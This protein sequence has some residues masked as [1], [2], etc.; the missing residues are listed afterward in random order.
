MRSGRIKILE[1]F[2]HLFSGQ[3]GKRRRF[4]RKKA[5]ENHSK[6]GKEPVVGRAKTLKAPLRRLHRRE[7]EKKGRWGGGR[8]R[9]I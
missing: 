8:E 6:G 1:F 2:L 3:G 7:N 9:Q 4:L 5:K